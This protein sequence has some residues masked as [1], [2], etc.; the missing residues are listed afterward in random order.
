MSYT[1]YNFWSKVVIWNPHCM[2]YLLFSQ[3]HSLSL[4]PQ[5]TFFWRGHLGNI[6]FQSILHWLSLMSDI[7][8]TYGRVSL[9]YRDH[10][11]MSNR[12]RLQWQTYLQCPCKKDKLKKLN[13]VKKIKQKIFFHF[14]HIV[15]LLIFMNC[16][17]C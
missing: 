1:I 7:F 5:L 14:I 9:E 3:L 16:W 13:K 4:C 15:I 12:S 6:V 17:K 10:I 8:R 2:L 11:I